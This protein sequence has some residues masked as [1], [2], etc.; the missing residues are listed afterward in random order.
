M[1][2]VAQQID[3]PFIDRGVYVVGHSLWLPNSFKYDKKTFVGRYYKVDKHDFLN[4]VVNYTDNCIDF[5]DSLCLD[6]D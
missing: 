4:C 6:I 5:A 1:K 2:Y 3:S